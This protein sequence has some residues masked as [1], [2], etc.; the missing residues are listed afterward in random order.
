MALAKKKQRNEKRLAIRKSFHPFEQAYFMSRPNPDI[1]R[2]KRQGTYQRLPGDE[3]TC[4]YCRITVRAPRVPQT[5]GNACK[6]GALHV[7]RDERG[8]HYLGDAPEQ[9]SKPATALSD[10]ERQETL[11]FMEMFNRI[12]RF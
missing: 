6:C 2:Q 3:G 12:R 4:V 1:V 8:A 7:L 9:V 5:S 11:D 10:A